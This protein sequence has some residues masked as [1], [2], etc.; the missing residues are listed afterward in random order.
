MKSAK[1]A[2]PQQPK[3]QPHSVE[4]EQAVLGSVMLFPE[5]A[6][7]LESLVVD[8]FFDS[9]NRTVAEIV[10]QRAKDRLPLDVITVAHALRLA[11]KLQCVGGIA[12]LGQL[13]ESIPISAHIQHYVDI[14]KESSLRRQL[15]KLLQE[16][17]DD[18]LGAAEYQ[19]AVSRI[20]AGI[21]SL[22]RGG[23]E[24]AFVEDGIDEMFM[25]MEYLYESKE[26]PPR[27]KT[28]L[29]DLDRQFFIEEDGLFVLAG[30][31]AMGKTSLA[32]GI[33]SHIAFVEDKPVAFFSMEMSR[34]Q[35]QRRILSHMSGV[36]AEKLRDPR[37]LDTERDLPR[38]LRARHELAAKSKRFALDDRKNL[39]ISDIRS[40]CRSVPDLSAVFIDYLGL[41]VSEDPKELR[42]QQVS[43]I[44]R[45]LKTF[46][47]EI[48][49]PI[50]VL[51]QLNRTL[52]K[53]PDKRPIPSDLRESGS[54]EQD[55]D[56]ILFVYRDEVYHPN[57]EDR[58]IA[59]IIIAKQREGAT[60][61]VRV[62][63]QPE[64]TRFLDLV[65]SI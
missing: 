59:E 36:P 63:W 2:A 47:S 4:A 3:E 38:L 64:T 34:K 41:I 61:T 54:V 50:F 58:G 15:A 14:V 18:V 25:E 33:A 1:K 20:L 65:D 40:F 17:Q 23:G 48:C 30:R 46:S 39:T 5:L 12:F 56:A 11:E 26:A 31:P 52:E 32:I 28:G 62:S 24:T 29:T 42:E 43:A 44:T 10:L 55:A 6:R 22:Q 51:S 49:A 45:E 7:H 57:T 19:Q 27:R 21:A 53:R 37:M 16:S 35:I 60:G 8:D 13:V 9:N